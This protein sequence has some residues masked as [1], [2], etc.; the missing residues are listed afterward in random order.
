MIR[1]KN[2]KKEEDILSQLRNGQLLSMGKQ[3]HLVIKLSM[4]AILAQ[5]SS[6][7]MQYIDA[8]MVGKL[9]ADDSAS[10]GLVSSTTW[11]FGGLCS[12][13]ATGFSVQV[14][15]NIG[16]GKNK[17]AQEVLRQSILVVLI[18]SM[19]L[20]LVGVAIS[21]Y[22]PGWLG[23][24]EKIRPNAIRYFF[25]YICSLPVLQLNYLAG[26]MLQ[27]SGNMRTPGLLNTL[28]CGMD[29]VFNALL[30][31]PSHEW[32]VFDYIITIPGAGLGVTGAAL[33]TALAEVITAS[34]M[35]WAL[36]YRSPI[37]RLANGGSWKVKSDC[38]LKALRIALPMGGE[39]FILTGAMIVTTR[40]VA[41]LGTVAIAANS[42]AITAESFCYMPG[43]GIAQAATTLVG[44]S[45]GAGRLELTRRFAR[46]TVY[47]GMAV[48]TITGALMFLIAPGMLA[49]LT[50]DTAVQALGVKVLRIEV[51]AEPMFAASIVAS[52]AL[53]GAGDTLI[54]SIMNLVSM[55]GVRLS[56]SV[57]LASHLGLV[58]VWIAMCVE[59]CFRGLLFLIR[60]HREKWIKI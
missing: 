45:V 9:G 42:F 54:P 7:I 33:G 3:L 34:L 36:C 47:L 14:A 51:F 22:L 17:K 18:F 60:L 27:C 19:L 15:H 10:I 16:A 29:V 57:L 58:G 11:L 41:P 8:S 35:L 24:E 49:L 40:I 26:N 38:L 12:A 59:L 5:I 50:P 13:A 52:G 31:F 30:I 43:Y 4:P 53:R 48:M 2:Q 55:W 37:L 56:L 32:K 39:H 46:M 25:I 21:G 6:I 44:H 20:V 28:M 23:G 1:K